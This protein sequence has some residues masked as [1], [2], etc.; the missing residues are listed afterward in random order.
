MKKYNKEKFL[1]V[2]SKNIGFF[3]WTGKGTKEDPIII[4]SI[5]NLSKQQLKK[6]EISTTCIAAKEGMVLEI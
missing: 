3:G 1:K 4:D 2:S 6:A 5:E